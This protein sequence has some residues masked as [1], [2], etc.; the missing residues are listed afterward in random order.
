MAVELYA[1][2][3]FTNSSRNTTRSKRGWNVGSGQA[4][5]AGP[6]EADF[7]L[8]NSNLWNESSGLTPGVTYSVSCTVTPTAGAVWVSLYKGDPYGSLD[9]GQSITAPTTLTYSVPWA[10]PS[11]QTFIALWMNGPVIITAPSIQSTAELSWAPVGSLHPALALFA[12]RVE[13]THTAAST[14]RV[15]YTTHIARHITNSSGLLTISRAGWYRVTANASG[16]WVSSATGAGRVIQLRRNTVFVEDSETDVPVVL[17]SS[18]GAFNLALCTYV[19][20]NAADTL[21]VTFGH[22]TNKSTGVS[23]NIEVAYVA[24]L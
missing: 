10:N 15:N 21:E 9:P 11:P 23:H 6:A 20:C 14:I 13:R 12:G 16:P 17:G 18:L 2:P 1:D 24:P 7:Y 22:G 19:S 8:N 4:V 5:W 3:T